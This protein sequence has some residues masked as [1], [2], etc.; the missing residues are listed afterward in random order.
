MLDIR[1]VREAPDKVRAGLQNRNEDPAH[2]DRILEL[3]EQRRALL[4]EKETL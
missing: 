3:D 1:L 4:V 2:V